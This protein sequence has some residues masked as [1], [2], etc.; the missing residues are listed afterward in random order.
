VSPDAIA[1]LETNQTQPRYITLYRLADALG[2]RSRA[3]QRD[4]SRFCGIC[5]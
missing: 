3:R 4:R 2:E 5:R 1:K